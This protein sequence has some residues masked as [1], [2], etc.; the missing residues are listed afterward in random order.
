MYFSYDSHLTPE[1]TAYLYAYVRKNREKLSDI[2][3]T[4]VPAME[5]FTVKQLYSGRLNK[6]L[7]YLY[8]ELI[9]GEMATDDN[10]R[11]IAELL[12][13]HRIEVDSPNITAAVVIDERLKEEMYYP[14]KNG[15]AYVDITSNDYTVLLEDAAG[16]RYYHTS[17]YVT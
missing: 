5:R 9:L 7:A 4:Y 10:L 3:D 8:N 15:V 13:R 12:V 16:N 17:D 14:L 6:P 11:E 2:Y 1:Q